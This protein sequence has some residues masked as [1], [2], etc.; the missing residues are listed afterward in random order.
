MRTILFGCASAVAMA[1]M[2]ACSSG[3]GRA[4]NVPVSVAGCIAQVDN[5]YMLV[6]SGAG[7]SGPVGTSGREQKRYKLL[8][9]GSV[10]VARYVNREV[11]VTGR[12]GEAQADGTTVLHVTQMSGGGECGQT[13]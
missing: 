12:P 5:D 3:S 8:D 1:G 4:S 11:R 2:F 9:D 6:P 7:A 13:K 10:G